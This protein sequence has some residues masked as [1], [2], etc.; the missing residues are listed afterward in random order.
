MPS[1]STTRQIRTQAGGNRPLHV[2]ELLRARLLAGGVPLTGVDAQVRRMLPYDLRRGL[3]WD[4]N[5]PFGN[6]LD[7]TPSANGP[8]DDH[9]VP[10]V[11]GGSSL[12]ASS[13]E[14]MP[15]INGVVPANIPFHHNNQIDVNRDGNV[16]DIDRSL[17]RQL[18]ARYLYV[19][20]MTL[21]DSGVYIPQFDANFDGDHMGFADREELAR[22]FAQWAINVVDFRDSDSI[23]SPF[24][25][26]VNPFGR[27]AAGRHH[28]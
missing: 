27:L 15:Q 26:D 11:P 18:Y 24:E 12:E 8:V 13:S 25:Y 1:I 16:D 20:M 28:Q 6:G 19:L 22:G 10:N 2:A 23:M 4:I 5:M 7:D 17:V 21:V 3:R 9:G 14:L